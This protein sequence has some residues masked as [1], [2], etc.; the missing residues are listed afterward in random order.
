MHQI[1][2]VGEK[3]EPGPGTI[4]MRLQTR[5]FAVAGGAL[6]S[7]TVFVLTLLVLAVFGR[8]TD[9]GLLRGILFGYSISVEGAFIGAMW[10]YAYGFMFGAALAF[11]YNIA[12]VPPPPPHLDW[13]G[14]ES[15][16]ES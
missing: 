8:D 1:V 11:T 13:E 14:A 2:V 4:L 15:K 10:A 9:A 7:A 6:A 3:V 5:A 12:V 16:E